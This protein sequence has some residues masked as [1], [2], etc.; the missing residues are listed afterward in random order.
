MGNAVGKRNKMDLRNI[1]PIPY[2]YY[3][4]DWINAQEEEYLLLQIRSSKAKWVEV[5]L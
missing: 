4:P 2:I 3:I 5:S 1:G